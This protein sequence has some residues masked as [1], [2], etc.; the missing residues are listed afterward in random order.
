MVQLEFQFSEDG[1]YKAESPRRLRDYHFWDAVHTAEKKLRQPDAYFQRYAASRY[2]YYRP[3]NAKEAR[4]KL[5]AI[6]KNSK[7]P[8]LEHWHLPKLKRYHFQDLVI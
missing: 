6:F 8:L 3:G 2:F 1:E 7:N 4:K 5:E